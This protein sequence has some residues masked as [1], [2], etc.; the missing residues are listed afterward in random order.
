M[1]RPSNAAGLSPRAARLDRR[2]GTPVDRRRKW[3]GILAVLAAA[4]LGA[5]M[6][7]QPA[8]GLKEATAAAERALVEK[9]GEAERARIARGVA[10]VAR[11]WR[12]D[13]GDA[14]AFREL[15]RSGVPAGRPRPRP[16][17]RAA[18][19]GVRG[20]RRPLQRHGAR[21]APR[22]RSRDRPRAPDRRAPRRLGP[23]EPPDRRPVLDAD[24]LRGA[25]QLPAQ[26]ARA[27]GCGRARSGAGGSGRRP[28]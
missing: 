23:V 25:A 1:H 14:A 26:H 15:R 4:S 28:A 12:T 10:Q 2:G 8:P 18:R 21:P 5:H 19:G 24:R 7:A 22:P 11:A 16:D 9:H 6:S 13:D 3:W 20:R 17:V 27:S